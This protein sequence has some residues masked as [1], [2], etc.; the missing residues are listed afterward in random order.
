MER[1]SPHQFLFFVLLFFCFH[2]AKAN[3]MPRT[4]GTTKTNTDNLEERLQSMTLSEKLGQM[5]LVDFNVAALPGGL[6]T[7]DQAIRELHIGG[8]WIQKKMNPDQLRRA[9]SRLQNSTDIPLFFAADY[10]RGAGYNGNV[11]TELPS[12]MAIGAT[13]DPRMAELAGRVVAKESR[14]LGVNVVFAPV[15]DVNNN[16]QNPIINIRS[17]G[18]D[19]QLVADMSEAFVRG[20]ERGGL[21]TTLKHFPGH[22]NT[23]TDTHS[24]QTSV[25]GKR[26][27]LDRTELRPYH[28]ILRSKTPPAFV[29]TGHLA[30]PG[31]D[32][33]GAPATFS[34]AM[35]EG[36]LRNE[37]GFDG[38]IIT[39][40]INMGA[41]TKH[42][43]F[44]ETIVRPIEAGADIV[45]LPTNP[46]R[47][48]EALKDAVSTGRLTEERIDQ[49]VRRILRAKERIEIPRALTS[50]TG[51]MAGTIAMEIGSEG[52][53]LAQMIADRA[54]TL[55]KNEDDTLPLAENSR[56][57]LVQLTFQRTASGFSEAMGTLAR[58]LSNAGHTVSECRVMAAS[59]LCDAKNATISSIMSQVNESDVVV[60]SL[61][62]RPSE[63]RGNVAL[64]ADQSALARQILASGKKVVVITFGNPYIMD[65]FRNVDA[66]VVGYDQAKHTAKAMSRLLTGNLRASGKLPVS[67]EYF[68]FGTNLGVN[69][70]SRRSSPAE[71]LR[72][73][74]PSKPE[75][76]LRTF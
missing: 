52:P 12:S 24:E 62:L 68:E 50:D 76:G 56:V 18:E 26:S 54:V 64:N 8:F 73:W 69:T 19:P 71:P 7:P 4:L 6:K 45:L 41:I 72:N 30:V 16:P 61:Y 40:G 22:G 57:S 28:Q 58:G 66:L 63:R 14:A 53:E 17:F 59:K 23:A 38:I 49:S 60:L 29:M 5:L 35:L 65:E 33:S 55:L 75:T 25:P 20:A 47:A 3:V 21:L 10:E 15:A 36:I 13:R 51:Y 2:A 27:E 46:R 37:M 32:P 42:Y 11:L 9:I 67:L 48:I 1:T 70:P 74:S 44:E 43:P 34:K 31:L 39:D